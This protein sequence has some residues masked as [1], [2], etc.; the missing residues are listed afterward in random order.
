MSNK[1]IWIGNFPA[2]I[3]FLPFCIK[4]FA[5]KAFYPENFITWQDLIKN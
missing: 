2:E 4:K 3:R 5:E 1:I